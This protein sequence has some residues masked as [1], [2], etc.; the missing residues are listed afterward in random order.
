MIRPLAL[1][2][3]LAALAYGSAA[4][5]QQTNPPSPPPMQSGGTMSQKSDPSASKSKAAAR[6]G[7]RAQG[8]KLDSIASGLNACQ[9]KSESERAPCIDQVIR[10]NGG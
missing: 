3:T 9:L 5:A 1:A 4:V 6:S 10:E 8:S 2:A 7:Q